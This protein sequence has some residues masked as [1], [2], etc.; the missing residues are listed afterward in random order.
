MFVHPISDIIDRDANCTTGHKTLPNS[1]REAQSY[2]QLDR[3]GYLLNK[4]ISSLTDQEPWRIEVGESAARPLVRKTP[5]AD[6]S[7]TDEAQKPAAAAPA[8]NW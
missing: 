1:L 8:I 3:Q 7:G 6:E 5:E 2:W 4:F